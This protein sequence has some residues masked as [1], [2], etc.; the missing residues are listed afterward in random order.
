M[1]KCLLRNYSLRQT[2]VNAVFF[3]TIFMH[4][5]SRTTHAYTVKARE[6]SYPV[7]FRL[8]PFPAEIY[9]FEHF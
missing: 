2:A 9:E 8:L 7:R 3:N 6:A 4:V 5:N 1:R